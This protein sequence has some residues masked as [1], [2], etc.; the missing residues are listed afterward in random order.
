MRFYLK[1]I[2]DNISNRSYY[3]DIFAGSLNSS[4]R[5]YFK[6]VMWLALIYTAFIAIFILPNF[7]DWS[8]QLVKNL[9][10]EYPAELVITVDQG[11]ISTNQTEPI[12]I[13]LALSERYLFN[14][15]PTASSTKD[16][17]LVI[18]TKKAFIADEAA[19]YRALMIL[20]EN[21]LVLVN[22]D[23][24]AVINILPTTAGGTITVND[25][26]ILA[27]KFQNYAYLLAPVL[28]LVIYFYSLVILTMLLVV[29]AII[30]LLT[31]LLFVLT[32]KP[33][34]Y[35]QALAVTLHA[36]TLF[37]LLNFIV[38]IIYPSFSVNFPFMVAFTLFVIYR[39][40]IRQ[41]KPAMIIPPPA[42]TIPTDSKK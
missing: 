11:Q 9:A 16:N 36:V 7:I 4:F 30:A 33:I 26:L 31:Y 5:Y 32:K 2:R 29:V 21:S 41:P 35:R 13:P 22:N 37:Y 8:R 23:G 38:F 25:V 19:S 15:V 17:L 6:M 20:T 1:K 10:T 3:E 39:N 28:V 42:P 40:L 12:K 34:T 27:Q 18:N 24:E 14:S